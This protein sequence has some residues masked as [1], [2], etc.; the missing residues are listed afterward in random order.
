MIVLP[1]ALRIILAIVAPP[2]LYI[3]FKLWH[4]VKTPPLQKSL[5]SGLLHLLLWWQY[6]FV[7]LL[8]A[9]WGL[10]II[11]CGRQSINGLIATIILSL[12]IGSLWIKYRMKS[13]DV[14]HGGPDS[15]IPDE[16]LFPSDHIAR[17]QFEGYVPPFP[18]WKDILFLFICE[19]IG[20]LV[21]IIF[22]SI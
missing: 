10:E 21:G 20:A 22:V 11:T 16:K 1:N 4:P 9:Y 8:A 19:G 12:V 18:A 14:H 5:A 6:A 13:A 3:L 2:T 17:T 7:I 15:S